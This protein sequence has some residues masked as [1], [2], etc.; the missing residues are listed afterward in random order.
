MRALEAIFTMP[1]S[2]L[3]PAV[4]ADEANN[5]R[6]PSMPRVPSYSLLESFSNEL[7]FRA[8]MTMHEH[9]DAEVKI[10]ESAA[11]PNHRPT[12]SLQHP[13]HEGDYK[14]LRARLNNGEAATLLSLSGNFAVALTP[15]K[16]GTSIEYT[17]RDR[18]PIPG[19]KTFELVQLTDKFQYKVHGVYGDLKGRAIVVMPN[20]NHDIIYVAFRGMRNRAKYPGEDV[21]PAHDRHNFSFAD[22]AAARWLP[23]NGMQVHAGVLDHHQRYAVPSS[24]PTVVGSTMTK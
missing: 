15:A 3:L 4:V 13:A 2:G 12:K 9:V 10:D 22:P 6:R 11:N 7:S 8:D 24:Q 14:W 18:V 17:V 23:E 19:K 20:D 5:D 1:S 16:V 21:G